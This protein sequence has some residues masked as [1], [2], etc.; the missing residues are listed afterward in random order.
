MFS[1]YYVGA[2]SLAAQLGR[3]YAAGDTS[4]APRR[5]H[6]EEDYAGRSLRG[7]VAIVTGA[8]SGVGFATAE[9]LCRKGALVVLACRDDYSRRIAETALKQRVRGS[10]VYTL[11]LDLASNSSIRAFVTAFHALNLPLHILVNNAA[12]MHCPWELNDQGV[13]RHLQVNFLGSFLLS[14]LLLPTMHA[15]SSPDWHGRIVNVAST[16]HNAVTFL[17]VSALHPV[18]QQAYNCYNAYTCSKLAI[19]M[20][21]YALARFVKHKGLHV[22]VNAADPGIVNTRLYRHVGCVPTLL[23]RL[24]GHRLLRTCTAG[25]APVLNVATS[26]DLESKSGLH[27]ADK[28]VRVCM[29]A[30]LLAGLPLCACPDLAQRA[31]SSPSLCSLV[32]QST[33][34]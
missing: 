15:S 3:D 27:F 23:F 11:P 20:G 5:R 25:A 32:L 29:C 1:T 18:E 6:R 9:G 24:L 4:K 10:S 13:E 28:T 22:S 16:V 21:T 26:D 12:V 17:D 34:L 33:F 31:A 7:R 30:L 2:Q 8:N 14:H 19:I